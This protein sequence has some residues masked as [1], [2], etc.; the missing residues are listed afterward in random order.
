MPDGTEDDRGD[1]D[2][3]RLEADAEV[4]AAV[5][6]AMESELKRQRAR[7]VQEIMGID[8]AEGVGRGDAHWEGGIDRELGTDRPD[9]PVD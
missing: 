4:G 2:T 6:D 5:D 8:R 7:F 1:D 3:T 9:D